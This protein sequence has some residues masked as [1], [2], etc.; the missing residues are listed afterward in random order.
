MD[1]SSILW[2]GLVYPFCISICQKTAAKTKKR[3]SVL[4]A[5]QDN[6]TLSHPLLQVKTEKRLCH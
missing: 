4:D 6:I 5:C 2:K 1:F 3:V